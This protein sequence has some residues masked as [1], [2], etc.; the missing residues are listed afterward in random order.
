[1]N[2]TKTTIT[3]LIRSMKDEINLL[4]NLKVDYYIVDYDGEPNRFRKNY[5]ERDWFT[6]CIN[7]IERGARAGNPG[8]LYIAAEI[9]NNYVPYSFQLAEEGDLFFSI[10]AAPQLYLLS[11]NAGFPHAMLWCSYCLSEGLHGF[12]KSPELSAALL[13]KYRETETQSKTIILPEFKFIEKELVEIETLIDEADYTENCTYAQT[14][15]D[16]E[17]DFDELPNPGYYELINR[18]EEFVEFYVRMGLP[19]EANMYQLCSMFDDEARHNREIK[20]DWL[21]WCLDQGL[22]M[23]F[24]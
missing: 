23:T 1:M 6:A 15:F 20:N 10:L 4:K 19:Y 17:R 16:P 5:R 14:G 12:E 11:A 21:K 24:D 13:Q 22:E 3:D 18:L 8:L 7:V 9:K 2:E